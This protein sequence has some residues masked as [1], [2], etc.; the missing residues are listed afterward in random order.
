MTLQTRILIMKIAT[1]GLL[2]A[3]GP[4]LALSVWAPADAVL[5]WF[6][7]LARLDSTHPQLSEPGGR[8]ITAICGGIVTG[9][10]IVLWQVTTRIY[11]KDPA[12]GRSIILPAILGW[13]V[14]DST[15]SVLAGAWFNAVLNTMFAACFLV[16]LL[17]KSQAVEQPA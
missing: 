5:Q 3:F 15:G 6:L 14:V 13:Y 17:W 16:P 1:V 7:G 4:I 9:L 2:L 12:L 10:G 11:A 8:L